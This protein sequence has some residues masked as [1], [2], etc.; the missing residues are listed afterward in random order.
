MPPRA[1][2]PEREIHAFRAELCRA[3][4]RRFADLGYAGVTLRGLAEDLGCS[5]MTPYRYFA[6][7]EAIFTAVRTAAYQRFAAGQEAAIA[8]SE[9]PFERLRATGEAY[10][11][12]AAEE[13]HAYRI[14]F[15]LAQAF[16]PDDTE[17]ADASARSW[18]PLRDAIA[19]VIDTGAL[20]GDPEILAHLFWAGLHGLV[21]LHLAG[22]LQLGHRLEDLVAPM[23]LTLFRGNQPEKGPKEKT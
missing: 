3:A 15:E 18:A 7:K 6:N 5:P 11:A 20:E 4:E 23:M 8:S 12:F 10:L 13:P 22:K 16:D 21:S 14:M 1:P 2:L 17:L 9:D 19:G